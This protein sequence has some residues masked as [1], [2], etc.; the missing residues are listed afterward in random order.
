MKDL[1]IK[2]IKTAL[3]ELDTVGPYFPG[4]DE[5]LDKARKALFQALEQLEQDLTESETE[6]PIAKIDR[7]FRGQ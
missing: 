5:A 3:D 2:L 4:D 6:D 7:L 1:C